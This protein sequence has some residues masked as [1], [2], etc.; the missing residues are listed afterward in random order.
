MLSELRCFLSF[1]TGEAEG[2]LAAMGK[3]LRSAATRASIDSIL[4]LLTA[5]LLGYEPSVALDELEALVAQV[6]H[7]LA[8]LKPGVCCRVGELLY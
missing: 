5:F 1:N 4:P 2:S 7:P 3:K 8:D 6:R